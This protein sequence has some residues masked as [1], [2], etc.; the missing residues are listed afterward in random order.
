MLQ[1]VLIAGQD[2]L[3]LTSLHLELFPWLQAVPV[4]AELLWHRDLHGEVMV[5]GGFFDFCCL[6]AAALTSF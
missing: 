2:S 1:S 5:P 6:E 3:D 4:Q